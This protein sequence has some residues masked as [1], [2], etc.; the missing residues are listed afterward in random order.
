MNLQIVKDPIPLLGTIIFGIVDRGSNLIQIRPIT[1]CPLD[2][3]F[4]S[5]NAGNKEL[6]KTHFMVELKHLLNFG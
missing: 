1:T 2:C 6:H 3:I 4:C 5:T